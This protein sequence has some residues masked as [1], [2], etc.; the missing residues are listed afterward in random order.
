M[1]LCQAHVPAADGGA[2]D[3]T[4]STY[5]PSAAS[6]PVPDV[7]EKPAHHRHASSS[8]MT[9]DVSTHR[10]SMRPFSAA[11]SHRPDSSSM[12]QVL[13][14]SMPRGY[15]G[16][17]SPYEPPASSWGQTGAGVQASIFQR[18]AEGPG[19]HSIGHHPSQSTAAPA[20]FRW[21]VGGHRT[22]YSR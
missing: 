15:G 6:S 16:L 18:L 14:Q 19:R 4:M 22:G 7:T 21:S 10:D 8:M 20:S 3:T 17:S 5:R 11:P 12:Q 2:F 1:Y 13:S 9:A